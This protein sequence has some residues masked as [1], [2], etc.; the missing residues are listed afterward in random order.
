M[1]G[2][3]DPREKQVTVVGAGFAGLIASYCLERAGYEVTLHEAQPRAGGLIVTQPTPFG[4]SEG[5]AHSLLATPALVKLCAEIGV[6][7][8]AGQA[9]AR[10]IWRNGRMRRVPLGMLEALATAGR[11]LRPAPSGASDDPGSLDLETWGRRHLGAAAVDYLLNPFLRGIYAARPAELLV[12]ATY[13]QL[14]VTPGESF[15]GAQRRRRREARA[16][17]TAPAPRS[18]LMAPRFGMQSLTDALAGKLRARRGSD[19]S[20]SYR[21]RPMSCSAC[22]PTK[23]RVCSAGRSVAARGARRAPV[24]RAGERHGVRREPRLRQRPAA[25]RRRAHA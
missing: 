10:Y 22:L 15:L 7:L 25:G 8:V 20:I 18:Q 19:P 14:L 4:P 11:L 16:A 13:P 3:L 21:M 2:R 17:S 23:R 9:K 1:I 12:A 24:L 6:E 5:A